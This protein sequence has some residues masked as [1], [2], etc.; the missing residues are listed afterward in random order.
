M[1][2]I[3][4]STLWTVFPEICAFTQPVIIVDTLSNMLTSEHSFPDFAIATVKTENK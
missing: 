2:G 4:Q 1:L 3:A